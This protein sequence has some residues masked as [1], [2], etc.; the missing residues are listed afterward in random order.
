LPFWKYFIG[1]QFHL[2]I[3]IDD[4]IFFNLVFIVLISNFFLSSFVKVIILFN[5]TLQ[6]E[7]CFLCQF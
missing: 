1:F 6:S 5:F 3:Q 4:I 2:S 7:H